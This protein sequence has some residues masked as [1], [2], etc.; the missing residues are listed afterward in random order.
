MFDRYSLTASANHVAGRFSVEVTEHYKPRYNAAPAQLLPV[1]TSSGRQGLSWFYWG[2]PPQ[3]A[4]NKN[5]G[6]KIINLS[7]ET[8]QEK[9]ILK[10]ALI[11]HRCI[12]PADGL[13][14]WKKLGKKTA[15]PHRFTVTDQE[16]FSFA[17]LWEEFEDEDGT[18]LHTFTI[19]TV[20]SNELMSAATERMPV[21]FNKEQED[22]WLSNELS[23]SA[24]IKMLAS[25]P[26]SKM[27][28]YTISPDI[29]NPKNDY[30][31]IILPT[32]AADQH[33]NL[34]LFD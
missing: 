1:I 16:I 19:I 20:L 25:Y 5:L 13:Y 9:P 26:A 28:V 3:F 31:S 12:I 6:E 14:G 34:T 4:R 22:R 10:K 27:S 21:I 8:L 11:R 24:L 2:R 18:S 15:I 33:G 30:P 29:S 7:L 23:E 17:G 32:P